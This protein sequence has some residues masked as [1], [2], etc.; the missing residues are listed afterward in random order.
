MKRKKEKK[1]RMEQMLEIRWKMTSVTPLP[2]NRTSLEHQ[3]NN[4][5]VA[6]T[7]AI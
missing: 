2:K 1:K 5:A 7:T 4:D 6:N 3:T